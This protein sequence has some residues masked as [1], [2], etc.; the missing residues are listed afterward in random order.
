MLI[1]DLSNVKSLKIVE[2]E[3]RVCLRN[4]A[5]YGKFI[6]PNTAQKLGKELSWIC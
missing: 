5:G 6:D 1:T 3:T 4:R 2:R